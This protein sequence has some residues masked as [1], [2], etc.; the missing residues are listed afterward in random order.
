LWILGTHLYG[1]LIELDVVTINIVMRTDWLLQLGRNDLARPIGSGSTCEVHDTSTGILEGSLEKT[2]GNAQSHTGAAESTLIV[3]YWPRVTLKLFEDVGDLEL[4][5]L[6]R[7]E[8]AGRGAKGRALRLL[9][10]GHTRAN[11][12]SK[13]QHFLHLLSSVVLI[14][15]KYVGLGALG[16]TKLMN[17]S[18]DDMNQHT[19]FTL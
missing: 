15:S 19:G 17:L 13:A 10:G 12:L 16:V 6:D 7:Q 2:N 9:L 1:L 3:G 11:T 14:A 5:L 18:L 8:E 4:G